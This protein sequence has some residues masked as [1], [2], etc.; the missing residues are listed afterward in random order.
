MKLQYATSKVDNTGSLEHRRATVDLNPTIAHVLSRDLYQRPIESMF[1]EI[2]INAID[3]HREVG[4]TRPVEIHLPT[5]WDESFF[6]RDY[7]PGLPHARLMDIYMAYGI[8]SRR[9]T[10]EVHGGLGLGTKSPLAYTSTFSVI[11]FFEGTKNSYLVYYDED[12]LPCVDHRESEPTI[13]PNGLLVSLVTVSSYDYTRF[14]DAARKILGRIPQ[15]VY[16]IVN[17]HAAKLV[18][19][20]DIYDT[21]GPLRLK[22]GS[23]FSVV[24]GYISYDIDVAAVIEYIS[25][26]QLSF[27]VD[28][29]VVSGAT[30]LTNMQASNKVE[31]VSAIGEYPVHPSRENINVTPRAMLQLCKDIQ[32]GLDVLFAESKELNIDRDS[33]Q[34]SVTGYL[35]PEKANVKI[36]GRLLTFPSWGRISMIPSQ[37]NTYLEF[38]RERQKVTYAH[39]KLL[40]C[41]LPP[42]VL[43]D[44]LGVGRTRYA[45]PENVQKEEASIWVFEKTEGKEDP[46]VTA[47]ANRYR[48][49]DLWDDIRA[50][51]AEVRAQKDLVVQTEA[52][53]NIRRNQN[54]ISNKLMLDTTHNV[55]L[56]NDGHVGNN[57]KSWFSSKHNVAS[58]QALKQKVFWVPT[59]QG[60]IKDQS[61]LTSIRE[62]NTLQPSIPKWRMP[63]ILGLPA[64]KGTKMIEN[65]FQPIGE[66]SAYLDTIT[67]SDSYRRKQALR[68]ADMCASWTTHGNTFAAYGPANWLL[69]L[70]NLVQKYSIHHV[71]G[72]LDTDWK[73]KAKLY[74]EEI[75]TRLPGTAMYHHYLME[76]EKA[77][78]WA[79][80]L[81][82]LTNNK[83]TGAKQK[84]DPYNLP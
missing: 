16:T 26:K 61:A 65:A 13:E 70:D 14:H 8:S 35:S 28:G 75:R 67:G 73:E 53:Y 55:L 39:G 44:Y 58:L 63:I 22:N 2:V 80:Q 9:D 17:D 38:L 64:S 37:L 24:M 34:L 30:V 20:E 74:V 15:Q 32:S 78:Q 56:L 23:G 33:M 81:A 54:R 43:T 36:R 31:I 18:I 79:E 40:I 50:Y 76:E 46:F 51:T 19:E 7:G 12:N 52:E 77:K 1:R 45:I 4:Q 29:Q 72:T 57:K 21:Y 41:G 5:I 62:F 3:A 42:T 49:I 48:S 66:L 10:N 27:I 83:P 84:N 6:V 69:R 68:T 59:I 25:S 82:E 47:I 60:C 11:S 71:R